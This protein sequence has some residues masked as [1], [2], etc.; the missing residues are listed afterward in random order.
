MSLSPSIVNIE[1]CNDPSRLDGRD[2]QK[3]SSIIQCSAQGAST[4]AGIASELATNEFL[5]AHAESAAYRK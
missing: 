2:F 1:A 3:R 4:L 5:Q